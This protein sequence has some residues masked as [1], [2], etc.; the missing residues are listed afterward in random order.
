[1]KGKVRAGIVGVSGYTGRELIRILSNHPFAEITEVYGEKTAGE[2]LSKIHPMLEFKDSLLVKDFFSSPHEAEVYFICVPH[3]KAQDY[4]AKLYSEGKR[5]IDLSADFRLKSAEAYEKTYGAKHSF[6]ELLENSVYGMPEFFKKEIAGA[7]IVANPGCL[8]RASLIALYPLVLKGL[9]DFDSPVVLDLK[10]G[11]SGAGK[12]LREDLHFP[13]MNENFKPYSPLNHRHVPEILQILKGEK[14]TALKLMFVPHLLPVDRG[15]LASVYLQI[16][17][18]VSKEID[19]IYRE[20][21]RDSPFIKVLKEGLPEIKMVNRTNNVHIAVR[22]NFNQVVVFV[23][24]DNLVSGASGTAVHNF[25][26][27]F[28]FEE[29]TSLLNLT[30]TYP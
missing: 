30:P 7:K 8:A 22:A 29:G 11:V 3:G 19:E 4:V 28:G 6:P 25:N 15:I 9:L 5:I 21:Y 24:L 18:N 16:K 2:D 26:L 13:H 12:S 10:T 1:M 27:M 23:A 20:F 17:E 14:E